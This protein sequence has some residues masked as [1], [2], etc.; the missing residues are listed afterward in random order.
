MVKGNIGAGCI[1]ASELNQA[2]LSQ[3]RSDL[4]IIDYFSETFSKVS[5]DGL[6]AKHYQDYN[7]IDEGFSGFWHDLLTEAG[8]AANPG[9]S[10]S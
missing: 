1:P 4:S 8:M 9:Y 7:E 3:N 6:S 5:S 2:I 10:T